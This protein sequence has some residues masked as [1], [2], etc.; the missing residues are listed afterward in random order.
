MGLGA[1]TSC[2]S[3]PDP[4]LLRIQVQ[5]R[6]KVYGNRQYRI[7]KIIQENQ[8]RARRI[9]DFRSMNIS[10]RQNRN[11]SGKAK[12][13]RRVSTVGFCPPSLD[14]QMITI[15]ITGSASKFFWRILRRVELD[16]KAIGNSLIANPAAATT[17]SRATGVLDDKGKSISADGWVAP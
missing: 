9:E 14:T 2:R 3:E 10:I 8:Q 5:G 16:S 11:F 7:G 12:R 13:I 6:F 15:G 17:Q 4:G 1:A